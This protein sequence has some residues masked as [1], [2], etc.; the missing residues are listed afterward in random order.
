[1]IELSVKQ[2]M[3]FRP[4]IDLQASI[5]VTE[6]PATSIQSCT[7]CLKSRLKL[8]IFC[9]ERV[10]FSVIYTILSVISSVN[11]FRKF[12]RKFVV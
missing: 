7:G 1:M 2:T 3:G 12:L 5:D 10:N 11:L 4:F 8:T 6:G 9:L